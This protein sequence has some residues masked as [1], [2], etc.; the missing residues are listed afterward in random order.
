MSLNPR[1]PFRFSIFLHFI[2][3]LFPKWNFFDQV[4][5]SFE[6]EVKASTNSPWQRISFAEERYRPSLFFNARLNLHLAHQNL[7]EHF[8][9]DLQELQKQN[10]QPSSDEIQNLASFR[11]LDSWVQWKL[12]RFFETPDTYQFKIV[13]IGSDHKEDL[14]ISHLIRRKTL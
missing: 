14:F 3:A 9:S 11:L 2:R 10:S 13:A 5:S 6:I 1:A 8:V 12:S 7:A 4:G